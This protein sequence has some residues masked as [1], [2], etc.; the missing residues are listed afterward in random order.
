QDNINVFLKACKSKFGLSDAQ[1]FNPSDLEDLSQRAIAETAQLKEEY[2]KRLRNVVVTIYWLGKYASKHY[3]GPQLDLSAYSAFVHHKQDVEIV[4]REFQREQ[5]SANTSANTWDWAHGGQGRPGQ[6][7]ASV[8]NSYHHTR[9]SSLDSFEKESFDSLDEPDGKMPMSRYSS[10]SALNK[11]RDSQNFHTFDSSYSDDKYSSLYRSSPDLAHIGSSH[12]RY[13]STDSMDGSHNS[14]HSRQGSDIQE[15]NYPTRRAGGQGLRKSSS[16]TDPLQFVKLK[17]AKDLAYTAEVQMRVAAESKLGA[18]LTRAKEDDADWQSN[19]STWKNRRKSQSEKNYLMSEEQQSEVTQTSAPKTYSQ[20]KEDRER[21]KS[22]GRTFYPIDDEG[23]DEAFTSEV[24]PKLLNSSVSLTQ[25]LPKNGVAA[26]AKEEDDDNEGNQNSQTSVSKL[27]NSIK[28]EDQN[29]SNNNHRYTKSLDEPP[30]AVGER[31]SRSRLAEKLRAYDDDDSDLSFSKVGSNTENRYQRFGAPSKTGAPTKHD[32]PAKQDVPTKVDRGYGSPQAPAAPTK[33]A[34]SANKD[35]GYNSSQSSGDW[36]GKNE[37]LSN[38]SVNNSSWISESSKQETSGVNVHKRDQDAFSR[39]SE[40]FTKSKDSLNKSESFSERDNQKITTTRNVGSRTQSKIGSIMQNFMDSES[41]TSQPKQGYNEKIDL[42]ARKSAFLKDN[43]DSKSAS[44]YHSHGSPHSEEDSE[45]SE[46]ERQVEEEKR[47]PWSSYTNTSIPPLPS[48][49]VTSSSY[50]TTTTTSAPPV[51]AVRQTSAVYSSYEKSSKKSVEKVIIISQKA[52][53]DK[54]FG[55]FLTG[56]LDKNAPITVSKVSLGSSADLN[57]LKVKDIILSV[58]QTSVSDMTTTQVGDIV[59][60]AVGTGYIEM[61]IRRDMQEDDFDDEDFSSSSDEGEQDLTSPGYKNSKESETEGQTSVMSGLAAERAWLEQQMGASEKWESETRQ[62]ETRQPATRQQLSREPETDQKKTVEVQSR[63]TLTV[64]RNQDSL[65]DTLSPSS[66]NTRP[67]PSTSQVLEDDSDG[68][69][70]PAILRKWQRQRQK[71]EYAIDTSNDISETF[72][73]I[74]LNASLPR[75]DSDFDRGTESYQSQDSSSRLTQPWDQKLNEWTEKQ[76]RERE[77]DTGY[78]VPDQARF[79]EQR[80]EL[81]EKYEQDLRKAEEKR[82]EKKRQEEELLQPELNTMRT[83][84]ERKAER[85]ARIQR[86][87][88]ESTQSTSETGS[89]HT[90]S[91]S[92]NINQQQQQYDEQLPAFYTKPSVPLTGQPGTFVIDPRNRQGPSENAPPLQFQIKLGSQPAV[93]PN[94]SAFL[95]AERERIRREELQ[96][97]AEERKRLEEDQMAREVEKMRAIKEK[98][99]EVLRAKQLLEQERQQF[100][101]EQE[102]FKRHKEQEQ[103]LLQQQQQRASYNHQQERQPVAAQRRSSGTGARERSPNMTDDSIR[104]PVNN[105]ASPPFR[106]SNSNIRNSGYQQVAKQDNGNKISQSSA[107]LNVKRWP[108]PRESSSSGGEDSDPAGSG[109]RFS[110]EQMLAMNRKATPMQTLPLET[111]EIKVQ[112]QQQANVPI[113]REAP[114]RVEIHTLNSVPKAKLRDPNEW[115]ANAANTPPS[116][117]QPEPR[118][119]AS[120]MD[121]K[122]G[123]GTAAG[124]RFSSTSTGDHWLIQEAERR[125]LA[126]SQPSSSYTSQVSGPI[127]PANDNRWRDSNGYGS[128]S[129]PQAI[130]QTLLQK[131]ASARGGSSEP[132]GLSSNSSRSSSRSP[133]LPPHDSYPQDTGQYGRSH[134]PREPYQPQQHSGRYA[135]PPSYAPPSPGENGL[136]VNGKQQCSHCSQDIG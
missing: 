68:S 92:F 51:P 83:L 109:R 120:W 31:S 21:R 49:T 82:Q 112:V 52:D 97:I 126:G 7:S 104:K 47:E 128:E 91:L 2:E 19:L 119:Q 16:S 85:R 135:Q 26:W 9:D 42:S 6:N 70:P 129:M 39:R 35:K 125:R 29:D 80:A 32:A 113:T 4:E 41:K 81:Q 79:E 69:G 43:E 27:N 102:E 71:E 34:T 100:L 118:H 89:S 64:D 127:K 54:G 124:K 76:D 93:D 45:S 77:L 136:P 55:F 133:S 87:A 99:A 14:G 86:S 48:S 36:R 94:T 33:L 105:Q 1:L 17:G 13:S 72:K 30:Q 20:M 74:S 63:L 130:R 101:K 88:A 28:A 60:R 24:A 111:Q 37:D 50:Q 123:A 53:S 62:L 75:L 61:K 18:S 115:Y 103:L 108:P 23:D 96:K 57:D 117:R 78:D 38:K 90:T 58:N 106:E 46:E 65:D 67:S 10:A 11:T 98:E 84:E 110:R 15:T 5:A 132:A 12:R 22:S 131:T 121:S 114:S 107:A 40:P 95:E 73:R 122:D 56:G 134:S 3:Q 116:P 66:V 25:S 59:A 44:T 8:D